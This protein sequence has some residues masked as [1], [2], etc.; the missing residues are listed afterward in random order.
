[1]PPSRLGPGALTHLRR[2]LRG[3]RPQWPLDAR[4][5]GPPRCTKPCAKRGAGSI[6]K[7]GWGRRRFRLCLTRFLIESAD[8]RPFKPARLSLVGVVQL[9]KTIQLRLGFGHTSNFALQGQPLP[10][11]DIAMKP[12]PNLAH[13]SVLGLSTM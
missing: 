8:F 3:P 1:M 2:L 13:G 10:L 12:V 5:S 9:L 11:S 6:V 7:S 4:D